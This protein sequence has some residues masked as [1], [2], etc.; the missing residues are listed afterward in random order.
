MNTKYS[1]FLA[2]REMHSKTALGLQSYPNQ[3]GLSQ[4][5]SNK[6]TENKCWV[7]VGRHM[8]SDVEKEDTYTLFF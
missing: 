7:G 1:G 4:K 2:F 5:I 8:P 6:M 3:N